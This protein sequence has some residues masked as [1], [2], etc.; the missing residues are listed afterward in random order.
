MLL[1]LRSSAALIVTTASF[2]V[3]TVSHPAYPD[4]S[5]FTGLTIT[6]CLLVRRNCARTPILAHFAR[7]G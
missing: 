5:I 2:A 1:Q 7:G 4:S 6:G 3:F